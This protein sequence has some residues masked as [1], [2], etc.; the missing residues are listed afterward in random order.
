MRQP[1]STQQ[2]LDT[3]EPHHLLDVAPCDDHAVQAQ[4][5]VTLTLATPPPSKSRPILPRVQRAESH[6]AYA[7]AT[8][9]TPQRKP[10]LVAVVVADAVVGA[11][12]V[13][14]VAVELMAVVVVVV[15]AVGEEAT[16]KA[17]VA[18]LVLR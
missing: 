16:A 7:N 17:K 12:A 9:C 11:V 13:A 1:G 6:A 14:V 18:R 15:V 5:H 4:K 2:H 10:I 3:K 8:E